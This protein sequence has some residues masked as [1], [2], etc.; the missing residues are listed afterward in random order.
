MV[1]KLFLINIMVYGLLENS[2]VS[3]YLNGL[4]GGGF[5]K[6]DKKLVFLV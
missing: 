1:S 5:C 3:K 4:N 2:S 6:Y